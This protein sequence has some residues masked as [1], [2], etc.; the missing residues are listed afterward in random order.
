[1]VRW[2]STLTGVVAVV[3]VVVV[4]V[5]AR[6]VDAGASVVDIVMELEAGDEAEDV[7]ASLQN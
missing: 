2:R 3:V 5:A 1:M 4:V 7:G 6:S